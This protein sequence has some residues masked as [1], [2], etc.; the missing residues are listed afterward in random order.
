[1]IYGILLVSIF[2]AMM[3]HELGHAY[4]MVKSGV[5]VKEIGLGL[6]FGPGFSVTIEREHDPEHPLTLSFYL[7]L[8]GAFVRPYDEKQVE[9]IDRKDAAFIYG[10]GVMANIFMMTITLIAYAACV[11]LNTAI[12][13]GGHTIPMP[14]ILASSIGCCIW[15][16]VS[17]RTLALYAFPIIGVFSLWFLVDILSNLSAHR[18]LEASGGIV[19]AGQIAERFADTAEHALFFFA[20]IS[21]ALAQF[22]L[23]PLYPLDGGHIAKI[24]LKRFVPILLPIF[25]RIGTMFF[26]V[27][28]IF[29]LGGDLRRIFLM[30]Q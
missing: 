7:F 21:F 24:H 20:L 25:D 22:N 4:A 15:M 5:A 2:V 1:M 10:A 29:T 13:I 6:P 26:V 12:T 17:P 11:G 14:V 28:I 19:A 16:F 8:L 18:L 27:I 9:A 23:I 30:F 3:G